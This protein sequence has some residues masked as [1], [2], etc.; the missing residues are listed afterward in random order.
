[1]RELGNS[2]Y[3]KKPPSSLLLSNALEAY[4]LSLLYAPSS[5]SSLS[6][7]A[8]ELALANRSAVYLEMTRHEG[9]DANKQR[10]LLT[11]ALEDARKA[12]ESP[13][14][15]KSQ[16]PKLM[17]RIEKITSLLRDLEETNQGTN[18]VRFLISNRK[19][20]INQSINRKP[21]LIFLDYFYCC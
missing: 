20:N 13:T 3:T 16:Q 18:S 11:F 19:L 21:K 17:Q 10:T 4:N 15:P 2:L 9:A 1:M 7:S 6:A 5:S 14:Y 12:V 8:Y